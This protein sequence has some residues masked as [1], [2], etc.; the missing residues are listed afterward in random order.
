MYPK[1]GSLNLIPSNYIIN[2]NIDKSIRN[3]DWVD[4]KT[5]LDKYI[6]SNPNDIYAQEVKDNVNEEYKEASHYR[7]F[8][9]GEITRVWVKK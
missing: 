1:F 4:A 8:V 6:L 9:F 3:N 5:L 2:E 7:K